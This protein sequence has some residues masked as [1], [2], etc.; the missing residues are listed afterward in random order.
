[1]AA[2]TFAAL[3]DRET[4]TGKGGLEKAVYVRIYAGEAGSRRF[5]GELKLRE[6]EVRGLA[7]ARIETVAL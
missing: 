4:Y 1:M 6:A 3:I 2:M 7:G 5:V